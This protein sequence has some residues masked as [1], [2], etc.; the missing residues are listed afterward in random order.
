MKIRLLIGFLCL[1]NFF[2]SQITQKICGQYGN[3][4][5]ENIPAID[6]SVTSYSIDLDSQDNIIIAHRSNDNYGNRIRKINKETGIITTMAGC[7]G[8]CQ[9]ILGG[10]ANQFSFIDPIYVSVDLN[11][12]IYFLDIANIIGGTRIY[13]IDA[14]DS[15]IHLVN[16]SVGIQCGTF[17]VMNGEIF[18]ANGSHQ[19]KKLSPNGSQEIIAGNWNGTS[20]YSQ[21]GTYASS[22]YLNSPSYVNV[23]PNGEIIF[24]DSGNHRIRKIMNG[25]IT[26][27]AGDGTTGSSCNNC[28]P[29]LSGFQSVY[30]LDID[31][32]E[33]IYLFDYALIKKI[34]V[35]NNNMSLVAGNGVLGSI[36]PNVLATQTPIYPNGNLCVDQIGNVNFITQSSLGA[37]ASPFSIFKIIPSSILNEI[38][39]PD[40]YICFGDSLNLG[41][42]SPNLSVNWSNGVV[43]N[44]NIFVDSSFSTILTVSNTNGCVLFNDEVNIFSV[45]KPQINQV[46][47]DYTCGIG[48]VKISANTN[49]VN[50]TIRWYSDSISGNSLYTGEQFTTPILTADSSFYA[51][52][53]D[54][55][56]QCVSSNRELVN[57]FI[58]PPNSCT[59]IPDNVF[60]SKLIQQ[61]IDDQLNDYVKTSK[62]DTL[63][64]LAIGSVA[65]PN[66][67]YDLTGIEDFVHL[68][69]FYAQSNHISNLDLSNNVQ[70]TTIDVQNNYIE[71]FNASMLP[72]LCTLRIH[73]NLLTCLNINNNNNQSLTELITYN[74]P[75]LTCIKVDNH[76]WVVQMMQQNPATHFW[77][78]NGLNYNDG[79][80]ITQQF[81]GTNCDNVYQ[82]YGCTDDNAVNY[83]YLANYDD[84]SCQYLGVVEQTY[85]N[86]QL[87]PNPS[88]NKIQIKSK[89]YPYEYT[90]Y[91][92]NG[93]VVKKG[94]INS[95]NDEIDILN[96]TSG[97][98][99]IENIELNEKMSFTKFH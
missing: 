84:G 32:N 82:V 9:N 12:D 55:I 14:S 29:L 87:F 52:A 27:I 98:Y 81:C 39:G 47:D 78:V 85:F 48:Y 80:Q 2:K 33:N 59:Y 11:D 38:A 49:S 83:N 89:S 35:C 6:A 23:R 95:E 50:S 24:C 16:G 62:I 43:N 54:T 30:G 57:A 37:M 58:N 72:S 26:T 56:Y 91:S 25:Q 40:Q 15:T 86:T 36:I 51:E 76:N 3:I 96:L 65:N 7:S 92:M 77:W 70:L 41:Y 68:K 94:S 66:K 53:Y 4:G 69:K 46:F 88:E 17:S 67:V 31:Q 20:G 90:I 93:I 10:L 97:F 22:S 75:N 13:K 8:N 71:F 79:S 1:T 45:P 74:N 28:N 19:I 61:N 5:G 73:N 34:D 99:I 63:Q 21:D 44:S 18:F 64:L 42:N 60:E